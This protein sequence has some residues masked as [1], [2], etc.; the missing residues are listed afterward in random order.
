MRTLVEREIREL[1]A[2]F[3]AWYQGTIDDTDSSFA[4]LENVLA[5]EFTL[6]TADGYTMPRER[7]LPL[8]RGEHANRPEIEIQ[9]DHIQLRLVSREIV[10]ITYQEHGTT[11]NGTRSTLITAILRRNP[12][13]P[14]GLEW[15]HIHEV[16]LPT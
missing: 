11:A 4:R 16:S 2:F 3:Q 12:N 9:V 13:T 1:H 10:L 15:V 5:P 14:N 7:L 8:L 6:I